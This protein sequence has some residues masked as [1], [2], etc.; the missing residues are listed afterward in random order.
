MRNSLV[1]GYGSAGIKHE[2]ILNEIGFKT[3]IFSRRK[4]KKF[5]NFPSLKDAL[6]TLKPSY[7]VI[8]N[9]T[10]EHFKTLKTVQN[11]QVENILVEKPIFHGFIK[12]CN[13]NNKKTFV[14]YNLR[15]HPLIIKLSNEIKNQKILSVDAKVGS[16]LPHWRKGRDYKEIYSTNKTKGGGVLRD[17][18]HEIDYLISIFGSV[19]EL[20]SLGGHFSSLSGNSDDIYKFI[21]KMEKCKIVSLSLDYLNRLHQREI[22][23]ITE[24]KS[25]F[26][27]LNRNIFC[28]NGSKEYQLTNFNSIKTYYDLHLD[29]IKDNGKIACRYEEAIE[30]LNVIVAAEKSNEEKKWIKL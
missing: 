27:D 13:I 7:V 15:F 20:V 5:Q 30:I 12:H 28:E 19:K 1:I 9:E 23:V 25:Y 4:L 21:L 16:Y 17:L 11:H 24:K 8:A 2:R 29:I 3:H 18:S 6:L 10:S 26:L 22:S 14:G